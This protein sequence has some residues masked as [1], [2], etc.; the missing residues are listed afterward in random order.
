MPHRAPLMRERLLAVVALL[1]V[2]VAVWRLEAGTSGLVIRHERAGPV[3]V[4]V[5]EPGEPGPRPSVVIAHGFAGS[6][7]LMQPFAVTLARNGYRAVTF[8]FPGHGRN[9]TPLRGGL[10]DDAA[11]S[12]TLLDS[13]GAV[14]AFTHALPG[15]DDRVVLLGHSM[16]ADIIARH[17]M[18]AD[19]VAAT[20]A[21]SVFSPGITA[22]APRNL[23]VIDG[24][25]EPAFLRDEGLRYLRMVGGP[26]A[27]P[28]VTYGRFAD[29]TARRLVL[30]DGAEHIA[31]LYSR[32]GLHE[33]T[34]WLDAALGHTSVGFV[35]RRGPWLGLLFLGLLTLARSLLLRLPRLASS[36]CGAGGGWRGL[37]LVAGAPAILTPLALWAVPI[38]LMPLLLGDYL[39]LHFA[40]YGVLT[41]TGLRIVGAPL[42]FAALR[43]PRL[44]LAAAVIAAIG[45]LA[46]GLAIERYV[47]AFVPATGSRLSLFPV[48]LLG[49][50]PFFLGDEWLTRGPAAPRGAYA[51]SKLLLLA[52]LA[53]AVLLR[54]AELFFLAIIVPVMVVFLVA[55][56]LIGRW[57]WHATGQPL[58]AGLGNAVALAWGI[59]ATFPIVAAP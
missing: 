4:T 49:L 47:T 26:D 54:P 41:V 28:G 16:A 59:A 32:Q 3:P 48:V 21:V 1:A 50:V 7:Q 10:A 17:A 18:A 30:V 45:I 13:L 55:Y 46:F 27:V 31:V 20:V 36:P 40:L 25:L 33:A 44:L 39:A 53:I 15:T 43:C 19:D 5:F 35:E 56:W 42:P 23:L 37:L 58:A 22:D 24:A 11:A 38:G 29:G 51:V 52:S 12:R 57:S 34:A 6:Q 9:P 2:A 8:D 14:I